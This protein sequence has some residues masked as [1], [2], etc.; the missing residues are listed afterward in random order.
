MGKTLD[1]LYNIGE[2]IYNT[3]AYKWD[4][5]SRPVLDNY[6]SP[7]AKYSNYEEASSL[8]KK[9][10]HYN[11]AIRYAKTMME[12]ASAQYMDDI[13]FWNERDERD[14][15]DQSSQVQRYEEA[16]FNL[17]YMYGNVDSGNSAVGYNQGDVSINPNDT[18]NK[19]VEQLKQVTEVVSG[20]FNLATDLVKSG[21]DIRLTDKR[22]AL[23]AWQEAL[24]HSQGKAIALQNNWTELLRNFSPDGKEVGYHFQNSIAFLSE[25]LGYELKVKENARLSSFLKYCDELY[26]N[27][28]TD[29]VKELFGDLNQ[30][31]DGIDN[32]G[33]QALL[34]LLSV[35]AVSQSQK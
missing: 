25:K 18:S 27:Q 23:T 26:R 17:G 12:S 21:F 22:T 32:K 29:M 1:Q 2:E 31:I 16:G 30:L 7:W 6:I 34:R 15:T 5:T 20:V 9:S 19:S 14:Y 8:Y 35:M 11:N 13:A 24:V 10:R 33:L 28:S 3:S 4:G